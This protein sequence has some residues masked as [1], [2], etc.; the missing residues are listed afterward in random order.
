MG[1]DLKRRR[2][3]YYAL[4]TGTAAVLGLL[5]LRVALL[6]TPPL[7]LE[8][9]RNRLTYFYVFAVTAVVFVTLGYVLG[10]KIDQLRRLAT[11]D[12]LTG[13]ANRRAFLDRLRDECRRAERYGSALS[14]LLIDIDGL[15]RVNDK[16]GHAAGDKALRTAAHAI[17]ST[18]RGTDVGA[19][20]GGDEFAIVA[21]STARREANRLAQRLLGQVARQANTG[22]VA[23]TVSVGVSTFE[24][25]TDPSPDVDSMLNTADA[26]LLRAKSAGRNQVKVA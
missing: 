16:H 3:V 17:N 5:L 4:L 9:L 7:A 26:A 20:W 14:L 2:S 22:E 13:L 25:T 10:R 1:W 24:P 21:P 6:P 12:A 18:M 23:V 8:F 19:R 15:K 11:T